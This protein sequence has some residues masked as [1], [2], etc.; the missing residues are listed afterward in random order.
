M[1]SNAYSFGGFKNS[2]ESNKPKWKRQANVTIETMSG[3]SVEGNRCILQY[4]LPD[5]MSAPTY[6]YYRLTNFY[7]NHRRYVASFD[8]NQLKGHARSFDDIDNSDCTPLKGNDTRKLPYYPCGLIAN[9]MFNDTFSN[10]V[11]QNPS[12]SSDNTTWTYVMESDEGIS[13]GSDKSLY[14]ETSYT[15]EQCLPPPNWQSRYPN[16]EYTSEYPPPNLKEWGAFQV[17]MRTGALPSFSKLYQKN[18]T[19]AMRV[20]W[21]EIEIDDCMSP[22]QI[23]ESLPLI[24]HL[25]FPTKEYA[26]TKSILISKVTVMGGRNSFLAWCFIAVGALCIVLAVVFTL[27]H[28]FHPRKLGDHTYLSWNQPTKQERVRES[29]TAVVASGRDI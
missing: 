25:V 12:N 15:P 3:Y 17:W 11:L 29:Q 4:Y 21:Y 5:E 9:S 28:M 24:S 23:C 26:G 2:I 18:T 6:F 14:G 1:P 20:G 16:G 10:P 22:I 13:W 27:T 8:A 7:Q 19:E